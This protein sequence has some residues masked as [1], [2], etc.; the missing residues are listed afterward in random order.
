M[1]KEVLFFENWLFESGESL[2]N[3]EFGE[4]VKALCKFV[5]DGEFTECESKAAQ[6]VLDTVVSV[7]RNMYGYDFCEE[8]YN[9]YEEKNS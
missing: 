3:E 8:A 9:N 7:L 5:Y 1:G 4:Y 2:T 6:A